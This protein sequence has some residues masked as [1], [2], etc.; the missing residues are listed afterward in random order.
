VSRA[1]VT[2]KDLDCGTSFPT[3]DSLGRYSLP[4]VPPVNYQISAQDK[5]FQLSVQ[6]PVVLVLNQ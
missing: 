2:A 4:R 6:S 1:T 5:G 3:A